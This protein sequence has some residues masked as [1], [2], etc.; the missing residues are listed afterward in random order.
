M[1]SSRLILG[2]ENA[3]ADERIFRQGGRQ[4]KIIHPI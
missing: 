4:V 1:L 2:L 3:L